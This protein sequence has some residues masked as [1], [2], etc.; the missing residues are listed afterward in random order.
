MYPRSQKYKYIRTFQEVSQNT[1]ITK[2]ELTRIKGPSLQKLATWFE[3][4]KLINARI[5]SIDNH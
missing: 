3:L 5:V 4:K 2:P 1:H